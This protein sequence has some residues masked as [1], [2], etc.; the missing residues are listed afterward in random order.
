MHNNIESYHKHSNPLLRNIPKQ[1]EKSVFQTRKDVVRS[2]NEIFEV[3]INLD[4]IHYTGKDSGYGWTFVISTLNKHW[5]SNRIHIYSDRK[6]PV[7]KEIYKNN[8]RTS[9]N[10]LQQLPILITAQHAS[11]FK[12]ETSLQLKSSMLKK[13][14]TP[15]SIYTG[16]SSQEEGFQFNEIHSVLH[17]GTKMMFVLNFEVTPKTPSGYKN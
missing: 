6:S 5:I 4:S 15:T 14:P 13:K 3:K 9:F 17:E 16:L 1:L 7:N 2:V 12:I 10:N 11:G 8:I